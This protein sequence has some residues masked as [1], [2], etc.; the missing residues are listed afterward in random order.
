[1]AGLGGYGTD[2]GPNNGITYVWGHD[3]GP[4]VGKVDLAYAYILTHIGVPMVYF[5][6]QQH[7]VG[8]PRPHRLSG[9]NKTWMIPGY[10]SHALGDGSGDIPNLVW[11]HQQFARGER[12]RSAGTTT[13]TSSPWNATTTTTATA[14]RRRR[15]PS[16]S[17]PST[18]P[19]GT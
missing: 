1:M 6:G 17:S 11:I 13:A 5:T 15:R 14:R 10:D 8:R 16:C 4:P 7:R 9:R 12:E 19:A 3:E 2:F 18:T